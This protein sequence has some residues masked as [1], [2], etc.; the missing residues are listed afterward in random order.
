M[1]FFFNQLLILQY[2]VFHATDVAEERTLMFFFA[3]QKAKVWQPGGG[4]RGAFQAIRE[5]AY[6]TL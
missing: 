4:G 2:N 3:Q 1:L 5:H 6:P